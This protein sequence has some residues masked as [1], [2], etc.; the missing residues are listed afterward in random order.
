VRASDAEIEAERDYLDTMRT[1]R[2]LAE[3]ENP[4][5]R[6]G[7]AQPAEVVDGSGRASN[8]SRAARTRQDRIRRANYPSIFG[9]RLFP[10]SDE[11]E[12]AEDPSRRDGT[13]CE[14]ILG[15]IVGSMFGLLAICF[16]FALRQGRTTRRK[17]KNGIY[18][19]FIARTML[20]LYLMN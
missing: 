3:A 20:Q 10:E 2:Q 14:F 13:W 9:P 8:I 5:R 15:F 7:P 19:G 1:I 6:A 4:R 18:S 17:F 11:P 16:L 12:H